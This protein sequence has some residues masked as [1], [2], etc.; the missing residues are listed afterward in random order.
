MSAPHKTALFCN[1]VTMKKPSHINE[2]GHVCRP[3]GELLQSIG[4]KWMVLVL[5]RL[6][7]RPKRFSELKRE[8]GTISQ[9]VLTSV[10]RDLERNG[11]VDR[12]VTPS[13]PPRVDYQLTELGESLLEPIH[14]LGIW[15]VENEDRVAKARTKFEEK[16]DLT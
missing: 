14:A 8:I 2:I 12:T 5:I 4:S 15:A 11:I 16:A 1:R 7:E 6:S 13:I 9:K 10:L 3:V